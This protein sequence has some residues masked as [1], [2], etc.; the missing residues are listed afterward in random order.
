MINVGILGSNFGKTHA[1]IYKRVGGFKVQKIF[2]RN[3][4]K[5]LKIKDELNISVTSNMEDIIFDPQIDLVDV[6]LPS[7]L[8]E[9]WVIKALKNGKD[10]FCET[11][12]TL[13]LESAKK[14]QKVSEEVGKF[15]YVDLFC[16]FSAPHKYAS[17]L[18][19][20]KKL[21]NIKAFNSYNKTPKIWGELGLKEN[22][23]SFHIH[24]FD[25]LNEVAKDPLS[26][27]ATGIGG[28]GKSSLTSII[29]YKNFIANI[30]SNSNLPTNSPFIVGFEIIC[31]NGS[32]EF[33]AKYGE[34]TIEYMAVNMES[35][36]S[37]LEL[38]MSDDYEEV[39]KHIRSCLQ[40]NEKSP[41]LDISNAIDSLKMVEMARESISKK[42]PLSVI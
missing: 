30:T 40:K 1:E 38:E 36:T 25:F 41:N 32:I 29:H 27:Y 20:S 9:E 2:G 23:I 5:L 3:S 15:V 16:K 28:N 34:K 24:N 10:V 39:I 4:E 17:D 6:C 26:L 33:N 35:K 21:G 18:I 8:H 22:I 42:V 13:T 7:E 14:I 31:E 37:E 12:V 19:K 11:P